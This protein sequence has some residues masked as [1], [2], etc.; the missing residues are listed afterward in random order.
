LRGQ[1]SCV[2]RKFVYCRVV[3]GLRERKKQATREALSWAALQL[4]VERG[5]ENVLVEDIA[6]AADVSPRT[7]NNY[8]SSK[9]EAIAWRQLNRAMRVGDLLRARPEA[10][11]LW[12]GIT[13]AFLAVYQA[14]MPEGERQPP[15][16]WVEGVRRMTSNPQMLGEVLKGYA[17]VQDELASAIADRLGV[18]LA[19]DM[20]PQI[21]AAA[22]MAA[23]Q[24]AQTRWIAADPPV[25]FGPLL[26]TAIRQLTEMQGERP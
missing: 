14:D 3:S 12:D 10:E 17:A 4:A 1:Q 15:P 24:V 22:V 23:S 2:A 18:D 13:E 25:P 7:F 6:A 16:G 11:P 26:R 8:F 5:V 9:Y 19:Q 21:V 20:Y